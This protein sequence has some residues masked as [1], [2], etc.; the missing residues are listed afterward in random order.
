MS[1]DTVNISEDTVI[2]MKAKLFWSI[3]FAVVLGTVYFASVMYTLDRINDRIT[4]F[5]IRVN[6]LFKKL[7]IDNPFTGDLNNE[8]RLPIPTPTL[9]PP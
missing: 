5:D 1:R 8:S 9:P 2:R 6:Y 4:Q 3:I 7:K